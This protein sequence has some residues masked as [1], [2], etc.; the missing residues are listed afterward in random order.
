MNKITSETPNKCLD[1]C[2]MPKLTATDYATLI[3][4]LVYTKNKELPVEI[5]DHTTNSNIKAQVQF[6]SVAYSEGEEGIS[7]S[8]IIKYTT[9]D[10]QEIK[11][12]SFESIG[13]RN[14]TKDRKSGTR[15]FYRYHINLEGEKAYRLTFNRRISK[16]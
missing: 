1:Y 16:S 12:L 14:V 5:I 2:D 10:S 9:S 15:T 7:D 3:R 4:A 11:T 8:I 6:F 13:R